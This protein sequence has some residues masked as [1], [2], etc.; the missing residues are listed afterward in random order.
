LMTAGNNAILFDQT[1]ATAGDT[2]IIGKSGYVKAVESVFMYGSHDKVINAGVLDGRVSLNGDHTTLNNSGLIHGQVAVLWS[3]DDAVITNSG[4]ITADNLAAINFVGHNMSITNS[5]VI[6]GNLRGINMDNDIVSGLIK[7]N[8]SGTISAGD[9]ALAVHS[10]ND[11]RVELTNSG[12][13]N[14]SIQLDDGKDVVT[15]SGTLTGGIAF[16]GGNDTFINT[17]T[18]NAMVTLGDGNDK[19]DTSKGD[20]SEAALDGGIGNDTYIVGIF[21]EHCFE[22]A[23]AGIDHIK[24]TASFT[25]GDNFENLT[26]LGTKA[27]NGTGNEL[28]NKLYGNSGNNK[29]QGLVGDDRLVGGKGTDVLT[30]GADADTFVF[31][32]GYGKDTVTDFKNGTDHFDLKSWSAITDFADLKAHHLTVSGDNL[33]ISH[34]TDKLVILDTAKGELDASDFL[35]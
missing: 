11:I 26:L 28:G 5:G 9:Y 17:G 22:G 18:V 20:F 30:G 10:A 35:F 13:M 33:I 19:L 25:L 32:T 4:N 31:K 16:G 21:G 6:H 1:T 24:S 14:G 7:I 15:N 2:V 29:I 27:I 3:G 34:G 8:N 23:N 12:T